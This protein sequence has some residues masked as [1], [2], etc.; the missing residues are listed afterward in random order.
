MRYTLQL[1]V[2]AICALS[3]LAWSQA[4]EKSKLT[5]AV[6]GKTTLFYL[7]LTIAERQGYFKAE[8]LDVEIADFAGG[9]KSLQALIGGSADVVAGGFDHTIV[10]QAKGQKLQSFVLL[11]ANPGISVGVSKAL[12]A[13]YRSPSD[14]KG[15]KVG[16]T[17]PG[18]TTHMLLNHLLA[19]ANVKPDQVSVIG[20]GAGPGAVAAMRSGQIDAVVNIEPA[21]SL[22]EK[23]GDMRVVH[24]T[25]SAA[26]VKAVFGGQMLSSCLYTKTEFVRENPKTVQA[27][28]N[29]MVR[30]LM[31]LQKASVDQVA[32]GVP[33][34]YLFGNREVYLAAFEKVRPTYSTD[35]LFNEAGIEN[36]YKV[37]AAHDPAVQR[38][39]AALL[40]ETY[41][42][43]FVQKAHEKYK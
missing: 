31:W 42:N 4:P 27:L 29:A 26:G 20:V 11:G 40:A 21:M 17:A 6:G 41:T 7:P 37:L 36:T 18:S 33:Q 22:L 1:F 34:E 13:S 15:L 43:S 35:G 12:A 23:S 14:L 2:A 9:A 25:S 16:V 32:A 30:S 28:A 8:G 24:E 5:L 38:G 39:G 3:S 10:M 19:G